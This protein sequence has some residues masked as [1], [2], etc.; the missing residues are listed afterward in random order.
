MLTQVK[1]I[2]VSITSFIVLACQGLCAQNSL[3]KYAIYFKDKQAHSF[4]PFTYFDTKAIERRLANNYSLY[5]PSDWPVNK[6]YIEEI[7]EIADSI[8]G[9][10]RW[11]NAAF[12]I[13]SEDQMEQINAFP[14][15]KEIAI[16]KTYPIPLAMVNTPVPEPFEELTIEDGEL[17]ISQTQR[18]QGSLYAERDIDGKNIRIAIFDAGF[19]SVDIHPAFEHIRKEN[20]I[21]KA[22]D[23]LKNRDHVYGFSSHGTMVLSC[24]AGVLDNNN[25]DNSPTKMGLATGAEFLLARTESGIFEPY[26]EEENWLAA[27]EWADKNG[28]HIINSSLGYTYHRYFPKDM[29]GSKSLVAKAANM[30]ASKGIL[31]INAAG[32]DGTGNWKYMNTPADADSV[33][34]V[35]GTDA[36]TNFHIPFSSY[37]PTADMRL[38][39]NVCAY[40]YALVAGKKG[41]TIAHGTSFS[42]PLVAGFAACAWQTRPTMTNMQLFSEIERSGELYPYFDYAH[43]YGVPQAGHFVKRLK[44]NTKP[45]FRLIT[46]EEE[47][48]VMINKT[49]FENEKAIQTKMLYYHIESPQGHLETYYLLSVNQYD[50]LKLSRNAFS[51]GY[52][53]RIHFDGYTEEC[54]F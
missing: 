48:R 33:L 49:Y 32:N 43:G 9:S 23:F 3:S 44:G 16:M 52:V 38:K 40:G 12:I 21:I 15:V 25:L 47:I 18:M 5:H 34:A 2:L 20:R 53:L 14:F 7:S 11:M 24:I 13:A 27:A 42:S 29:D 28:A 54:N 17:L 26:S 39:P 22:W 37:G 51:S 1:I 10:S 50:V 45:T 36:E 46:S 4:D 6:S 35:G 41:T 30:A 19:P 31:V 8:C